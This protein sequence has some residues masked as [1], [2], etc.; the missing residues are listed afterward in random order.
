MKYKAK[1]NRQQAE[2]IKEW[3]EHFVSYAAHPQAKSDMPF[4]FLCSVLDEIRLDLE[5]RLCDRQ[6]QKFNITWNATKALAFHLMVVQDNSLDPY[7]YEGNLLH[8][9]SGEIHQLFS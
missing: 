8:R 5:R 6:Q 1:I 9:M 7:G 2:M 3:L 4:K